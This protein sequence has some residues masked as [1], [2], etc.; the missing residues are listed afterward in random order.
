MVTGRDLAVAD[1]PILISNNRG[2]ADTSFAPGLGEIS[3]REKAV[4]KRKT[5]GGRRSIC[6]VLLSN[7]TI[8]S[9]R[10]GEMERRTAASLAVKHGRL[11]WMDVGW[12]ILETKL[13][14]LKLAKEGMNAEI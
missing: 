7:C 9:R 5:Y 11:G 3:R 12:L 13:M 6:V 8:C 4:F 1:R 2:A 14:H 10:S